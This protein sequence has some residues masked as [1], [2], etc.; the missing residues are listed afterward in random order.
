MMT[1]EPWAERLRLRYRL[2]KLRALC[3]LLRVLQRYRVIP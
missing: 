3:W 2:W 1:I